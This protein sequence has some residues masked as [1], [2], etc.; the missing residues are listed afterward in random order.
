MRFLRHLLRLVRDLFAFAWQEKVW[1]MVPMVL[2]LLG[3]A[4]LVVGTQAA[5]PLLY[6]LF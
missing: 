5:T 2:G 1:W 6:A 3:L 4:L